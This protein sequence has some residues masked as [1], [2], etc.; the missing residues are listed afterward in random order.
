MLQKPGT[1][2][3]IT[4]KTGRPMSQ[5]VKGGKPRIEHMFSAVAPV[6]AVPVVQ[7][8]GRER[9]IAGSRGT[10]DQGLLYAL[11]TLYFEV[12]LRSLP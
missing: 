8:Q 6:A 7:Q 10:A 4:A 11:E 9:P 12:R 2:F 3:C 1:M 5:M